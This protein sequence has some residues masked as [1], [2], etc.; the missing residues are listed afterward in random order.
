MPS[1]IWD[2]LIYRALTGIGE[3]MQMA[4]VCRR[5]QL[6]SPQAVVFHWLRDSLVRG[7]GGFGGP[8]WAP[9]L[10]SR[11]RE[12]E[13]AVRLLRLDRG[14]HGRRRAVRRA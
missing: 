3:G 1:G 7:R 9:K 11:S 12:L 10:P 5:G 14:R 6:L 8:G 2:M 13:G 4:P